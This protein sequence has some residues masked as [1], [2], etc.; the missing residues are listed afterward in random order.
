MQ[1]PR[2]KNGECSDIFL[3]SYLFKRD[4]FGNH[5]CCAYQGEGDTTKPLKT[6]DGKPQRCPECLKEFKMVLR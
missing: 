1:K 3:C 2:Y 6:I 4:M 5:S